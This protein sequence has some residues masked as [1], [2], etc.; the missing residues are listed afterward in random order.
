MSTF[1]LANPQSVSLNTTPPSGPTHLN[2]CEWEVAAL[3]HAADSISADLSQN[4]RFTS[5]MSTAPYSTGD[6]ERAIFGR[7]SRRICELRTTSTNEKSGRTIPYNRCE[8][9]RKSRQMFSRWLPL[10]FAVVAFAA[11]A[12]TPAPAAQPA[13]AATPPVPEA[14]TQWS[15]QAL[16]RIVVI[17]VSLA[18]ASSVQQQIDA[19]DAA[20]EK[21]DG[22]F[23][24]FDVHPAQ[25][26]DLSDIA[27]E[28]VMREI[29]SIATTVTSIDKVI[30]GRAV[31]LEMQLRELSALTER[32]KALRSDRSSGV[33][34][35]ALTTRLD[36]IV[37]EV[38][39]LTA[40]VGDRLNEVATL[41]NQILT[42]NERIGVLQKNIDKVNAGRLRELLRFEQTPLWKVS[43]AALADTARNS[44]EFAVRNVPQA[45]REFAS[46]QF[47]DVVLH[48]MLLAVVFWL[49]LA[50]R[51]SHNLAQNAQVRSRALERPASASVLVAVMASPL[52]YPVAPLVVRSLIVVVLLVA[53][54][55][56]LT[57]YLDR[58]LWKQL[59][60]ITGLAIVDRLLMAL[61]L[62]VLMQRLAEL[63]L[64]AATIGVLA[65]ALA[66]HV[67]RGFGLSPPRQRYVRWLLGGGLLLSVAG[68]IFNVLGNSTLAAALQGGVVNSI[69]LAAGMHAVV[70]VLNE[71]AHLIAEA[72]ER[73]GVRSVLRH[74]SQ[75][76][77]SLSSI[78]SWAG[79]VAWVWYATVMFRVEAPLL[80]ALSTVLAAKWTIGAI[81]VSLG[82]TLAFVLAVW[83]AY[84]VSRITQIVLNDDL[85]P[86]FPLPRGVPNAISVIANYTIVLIGIFIG[87]GILGIGVSNLALIVG[88]LG[89][90]IGFGLQNIVSNV[91]SGL[92]LLFERPVQVGDSVQ[93]GTVSGRVSH[94]GFRASNIRTYSGA[95][96]IVPNSELL[97]AQMTNWT[98]SDR[99]RR[100]EIVVGVAYGTDPERVETLLMEMMKADPAVLVDPPPLVVFEAFGDSA[101]QFRIYAWVAEFDEGPKTLHRLNVSIARVFAAEGIEI[102]FPQRDLHLRTVPP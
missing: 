12:A 8:T 71:M 50:L 34:P 2:T 43:G 53:M 31:D 87:A 84:H 67:E 86:K 102:P 16:E 48:I 1:S 59:F 82:Q 15:Q 7:M 76:V 45:L 75:F 62:E 14:V 32:A 54:L 96:V 36:R 97:S 4:E 98:L 19:F 55:R 42:L 33:L 46:D 51:R 25:I 69:L 80:G 23:K 29:S 79:F 49:V 21:Y 26:G 37:R 60:A 77:H 57:L 61:S 56:M 70:R 100:L 39:P 63:S 64:S 65:W 5:T 93:I 66:A 13:P 72:L 41:Q 27:L 35:E 92:I 73:R 91:V 11:G 24:R 9:Y 101:L 17:R 88:A 99:R 83:L 74:R 52:V 58:S 6:F 78:C 90:G 18:A 22:R 68:V 47:Q 85:L 28:D 30:E 81:T 10:L 3:Q 95:E 38:A 20:A 89:V 94:I 40:A 44:T